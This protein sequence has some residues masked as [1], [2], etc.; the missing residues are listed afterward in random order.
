[1]HRFSAWLDLKIIGS[2]TVDGLLVVGSDEKRPRVVE[3][4]GLIRKHDAV[5]Y[6]RLIQD[7]ERILIGVLSGARASFV[8]ATRT[9]QLEE[10]FVLDEK[11]TLELIATV[12]VHEATHGRLHRCG[13]GYGED[14][15]A[16]VEE[17][18]LKREIAFA[19]KLPV[20]LQARNQAERTMEAMPDLSNAAIA[21]RNQE[22]G[23]DAL[24]Y[25]GAPEW[26]IKSL[27][28]TAICARRISLALGILKKSS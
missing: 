16:R 9:C 6:G 22:G 3:A 21:T 20:G 10:R 11:T 19:T 25:L 17:I 24:R 12:I 23:K 18:C 15:R 7:F 2:E 28:T 26:L 27:I 14:I 1:M 8:P 13:I 5:R 4:L